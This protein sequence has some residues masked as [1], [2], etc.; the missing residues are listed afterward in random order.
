MGLSEM[1]ISPHRFWLSEYDVPLRPPHARHPA[2]V[3]KFRASR[4]NDGTNAY[5]DLD[6][7]SDAN[8][9]HS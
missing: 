8:K 5:Q 1:S 9:Q 2:I 3:T 6:S 4:T 7:I